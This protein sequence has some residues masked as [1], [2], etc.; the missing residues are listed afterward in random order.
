MSGAHAPCSEACRHDRAER[1]F[2]STPESEIGRFVAL[3]EGG[4][5]GGRDDRAPHGRFGE[6]EDPEGDAD[7]GHR[8]DPLE[9]GA[10]AFG[11]GR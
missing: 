11:A 1:A 7:A 9:A 2:E 5:V 8:V 10:V 4:G 6:V 3:V